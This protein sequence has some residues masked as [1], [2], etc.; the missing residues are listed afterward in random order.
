MSWNV[1]DK[2]QYMASCILCF[3]RTTFSSVASDVDLR[4]NCIDNQWVYEEIFVVKTT[5]ICAV[6]VFVPKLYF[7]LLY[8]SRSCGWFA[9]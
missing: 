6:K 4:H 9:E 3:R 2:G 5:H 7:A 1:W 8:L